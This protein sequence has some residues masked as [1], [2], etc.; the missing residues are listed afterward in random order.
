MK[1]LYRISMAHTAIIPWIVM[2]KSHHNYYGWHVM[3]SRE[4]QNILVGRQCDFADVPSRNPYKGFVTPTGLSNI[5]E[6]DWDVA[7]VYIDRD[8]CFP[9]VTAHKT[10]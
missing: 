4:H 8:D 6:Y 2:G 10:K 3:V 9:T 1:K 5:Q 7:Q